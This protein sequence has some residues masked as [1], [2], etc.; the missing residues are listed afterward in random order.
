MARLGVV[1]FESY[2]QVR[3]VRSKGCC[4]VIPNPTSGISGSLFI[5][6]LVYTERK[7]ANQL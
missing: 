1:S 3:L 7:W 2:M 6:F 5:S 4:I